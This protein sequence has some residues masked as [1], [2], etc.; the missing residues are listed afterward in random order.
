[1]DFEELKMAWQELD[2]RV[3]AIETTDAN[4]ARLDRTRGAMHRFTRLVIFELAA[5]IALALL[6]GAAWSMP[7]DG[8]WVMI[9]SMALQA[10]AIAL[11]ASAAWQMKAIRGLDYAMPVLALQR[12]LQ[13]MKAH[14]VQATRWTLLLAPLMW[15]PLAIVAAH[16]L[17]A[18]D[19]VRAFGMPW[20]AANLAFGIAFIPAAIGLCRRVLGR[21][22]AAPWV[23]RLSDDIAGRSL[24]A[25]IESLG[26]LDRF[27]KADSAPGN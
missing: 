4:R 7:A 23:Q 5:A 3:A 18:F 20:I 14:R 26:E 2:R 6:T 10:G 8:P 19:L 22:G 13:T 27:A 16:A 15:T 21:R 17:F 1:M 12:R 25:A 24:V 9:S 11:L